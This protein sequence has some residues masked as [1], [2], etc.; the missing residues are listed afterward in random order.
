MTMGRT[1]VRYTVKAGMEQH[2]AE[3]VRAVYG[4]LAELRPEG[5]SYAT[6]RLDDGRTFIHVAEQEGDGAGPLPGLPAFR[7][8]QAAIGDRCEWGPLASRA[9]LIG[10]F[11]GATH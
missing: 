7:A 9:E 10:R 2:N 1:V 3:L 8:F 4:E 11:A 6:Y 5:F